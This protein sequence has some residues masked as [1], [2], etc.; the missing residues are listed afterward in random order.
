MGR[1]QSQAGLA[2]LIGNLV[3]IASMIVVCAITDQIW[4]LAVFA[5]GEAIVAREAIIHG[6]RARRDESGISPAS[7]EQ[8]G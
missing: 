4:L 6:P 8:S 2:W 3:G 7:A 5:I 1:A